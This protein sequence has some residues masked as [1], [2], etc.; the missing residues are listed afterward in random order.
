MYTCN[1]INHSFTSVYL[2]INYIIEF[3]YFIFVV[4]MFLLKLLG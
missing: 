2:H 1:I 3:M 4:Y